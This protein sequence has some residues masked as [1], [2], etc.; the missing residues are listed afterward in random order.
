[1]RHKILY[2]HSTNMYDNL[3]DEEMLRRDGRLFYVHV[4]ACVPMSA[5]Q[6][7]LAEKF[8]I[9]VESIRGAMDKLLFLG[10]DAMGERATA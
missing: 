10:P 5:K 4:R 2:I 8:T 9:P 7:K 1:M 3:P 6:K